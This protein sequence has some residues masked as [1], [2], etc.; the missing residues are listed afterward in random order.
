ML[1]LF[2]DRKAS[3]C[4]HTPH[5]YLQWKS[6]LNFDLVIFAG[7]QFLHKFKK[8][9]SKV[10]RRCCWSS[11]RHQGEMYIGGGKPLWLPVNT[12]NPSV[13]MFQYLVTLWKTTSIINFYSRSL[14][15]LTQM[16][17]IFWPNNIK[18]APT[19]QS[20]T[21]SCLRSINA[22]KTVARE[23]SLTS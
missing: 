2:L 10:L 15:F 13:R 14:F 8:I 1:S 17:C 12:N 22:S 16:G 21:R 3:K 4:T 7:L 11:Q 9:C 18:T 5:H 6:V 20:L 19:P 23:H